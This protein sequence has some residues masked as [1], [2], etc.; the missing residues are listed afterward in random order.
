MISQF[1]SRDGTELSSELLRSY[2]KDTVGST[3]EQHFDLLL[4]AEMIRKNELSSVEDTATSLSKVD[5]FLHCSVLK[6]EILKMQSFLQMKS[7]RPLTVFL[8]SQYTFEPGFHHWKRLV[9]EQTDSTIIQAEATDT[10]LQSF[11]QAEDRVEAA[12]KSSDNV[13]SS[14]DLMTKILEH[15]D[16]SISSGHLVE[17]MLDFFLTEDVSQKLNPSV[18]NQLFN[19]ETAMEIL[20]I[21][22]QEKLKSFGSSVQDKATVLSAR[23]LN[24]MLIQEDWEWFFGDTSEYVSKVV[25]NSEKILSLA[26]PENIESSRMAAAEALLAYLPFFKLSRVEKKVLILQFG[27]VN[28]LNSCLV[29][30]QDEDQEVRDLV[31][32]FSGQL[33]RSASKHYII[34]LFTVDPQAQLEQSVREGLPGRL[35]EAG[36]VVRAGPAQSGGGDVHSSHGLRRP[37]RPAQPL[38]HLLQQ[39]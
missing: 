9:G 31:I 28:I 25:E 34:I 10:D 8:S 1:K 33:P 13:E 23:C 14:L 11:E 24:I 4:L 36:G 22:D 18:N 32:R 16:S 20:D 3:N 15:Q 19:S 39:E 30:L 6:I 35:L 38:R 12:V 7:D 37:S 26:A 2:Q 17:K 29:L 5:E 27:F 21:L